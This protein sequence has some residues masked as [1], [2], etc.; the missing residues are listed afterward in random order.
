MYLTVHLISSHPF[1]LTWTSLCAKLM[2]Y[3]MLLFLI[4]VSIQIHK[5]VFGKL[6]FGTWPWLQNLPECLKASPES[7]PSWLVHF[8]LNIMYI[9]H[10]CMT[11]EWTWRSV[12]LY[13]LYESWDLQLWSLLLMLTN[14]FLLMTHGYYLDVKNTKSWQP[15]ECLIHWVGAHKTRAWSLNI[16]Q[17]PPRPWGSSR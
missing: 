7:S 4:H 16:P 15:T 2:C 14:L 8:C 11:S 1:L 5:E 10:Q 13:V 3:S 12:L 9:T 6:A 17:Q